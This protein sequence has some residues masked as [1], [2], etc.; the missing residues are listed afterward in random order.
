MRRVLIAAFVCFLLLLTGCKGGYPQGP[1]G[2]VVGRSTAQ[3]P[4][5]KSRVYQLTTV[6]NGQ[7]STFKV[8]ITD[9]NSCPQ[10]ASYPA[11]TQTG[12]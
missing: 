10:A 9:Y 3:D 12:E 11:C 5:T 6:E 1:A 7:R 4:A 2:E 8:H